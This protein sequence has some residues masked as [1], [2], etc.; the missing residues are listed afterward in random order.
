MALKATLQRSLKEAYRWLHYRIVRILRT[1]S[2]IAKRIELIASVSA[3]LISLFAVGLS[4]WQLEVGREHNRLSVRPLVIVTPYLEGPGGRNGLY[5]SNEGLGPAVLK[6]M[7]AVVAGK[8]F[9]GLGMSHWRQI[10]KELNANPLCFSQAWPTYESVLKVGEELPILSLTK[11]DL[12]ICGSAAFELLTQRK[13]S[14][15]VDY[16]SLY[17]EAFVWSGSAQVNETFTP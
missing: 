12:P 3:V 2:M 8:S 10:L 16:A 17:G 9:G 5:L 4:W 1:G 7:K 11:A 6:D 15:Q 14:M 13:M